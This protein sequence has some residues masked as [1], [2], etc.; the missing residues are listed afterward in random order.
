MA[1]NQYN[2]PLD[3][4]TEYITSEEKYIK[5]VTIFVSN[6]I[7]YYNPDC[8]STINSDDLYNLF[9]SGK[10]YVVNASL[11]VEW[12][13]CYV[14]YDNQGNV[15]LYGSNGSYIAESAEYQPGEK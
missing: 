9:K 15:S 5:S 3:E 14:K 8:T 7:A 6:D 10:L 2:K 1:Q 11:G 13:P 4:F 12:V